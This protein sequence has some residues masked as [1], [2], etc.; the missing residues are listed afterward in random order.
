MKR[1]FFAVF[2]PVIIIAAAILATGSNCGP[3]PGPTI[4]STCDTLTSSFMQ[5]YNVQ[6]GT[7]FNTYQSKVFEYSFK[8]SADAA[9]CY[10][11]YQGMP[12]INGLA[13]YKIEVLNAVNTV[14]YSSLYSFP[15]VARGYRAPSTT[16]N[17]NAN[18]EYKIR[19]TL[20]DNMGSAANDVCYFKQVSGTFTPIT[21]G[22]LTITGTATYNFGTGSTLVATSTNGIIPCIDVVLKY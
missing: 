15:S 3:G 7:Q 14:L 19:R 8:S 1:Y 5:L 9:I 11:G 10:F 13:Y 20:I 16:I 22:Q 6:S 4:A 2:I 18:T 12:A 17:I 21:S